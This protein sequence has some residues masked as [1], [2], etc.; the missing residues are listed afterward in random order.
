MLFDALSVFGTWNGAKP[1]GDEVNGMEGSESG[2]GIVRDAAK[3][4]RV[5][6]LPRW[7][8]GVADDGAVRE[9][10]LA[11]R[12]D[13]DAAEIQLCVIG[14]SRLNET[15]RRPLTQQPRQQLN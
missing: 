3:S 14:A 12:E 2:Q 6:Q 5:C 10:V 4:R 13:S 11:A 7:V 1:S 8:D 9:R 15:D